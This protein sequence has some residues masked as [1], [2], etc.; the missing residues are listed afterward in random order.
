VPIIFITAFDEYALDAFNVND[1]DYVLKPFNLKTITDSINKFKTLTSNKSENNIDKLISYLQNKHSKRGSILVYQREKIIP[2]NTDELALLYTENELIKA[3]CFNGKQY[4]TNI[5][6]E[7]SEKTLAPDF[8]R[9]NRQHLINRKAI[10]DVSQHF[11]RK[12]LLNLNISYSEKILIS[13]EKSPT[14]LNWLS[15]V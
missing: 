8:F 3:L 4:V 11:G 2:V 5:T 6:L 9:A 1:I 7:E 12:L 13:K 14:F 15:Q 10:I